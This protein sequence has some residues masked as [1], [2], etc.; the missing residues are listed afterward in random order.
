MDSDAVPILDIL[1]LSLDELKLLLGIVDEGAK[2]FLLALADIV[3]EEFVYFSLDVTRGV[4][5]YMAEGL[6]LAV[7]V[8][9]EVL[10]ALRQSH[11]GLEVYY[12]GRCVGN[13][14]ERL[15]K[16]LQVMQIGI[17]TGKVFHILR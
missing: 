12:L 16:Q 3:A 7:D 2:L 5:E 8:G 10:G 17:I 14:W 4:L 11:N 9:K 13:R 15:R 1:L 6:A